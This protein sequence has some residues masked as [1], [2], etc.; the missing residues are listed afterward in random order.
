MKRA[1]ALL[2][3]CEFLATGRASAQGAP[4]PPPQTN[5]SPIEVTAQPEHG[6]P[7]T[8]VTIQGTVAVKG[9]NAVTITVKPPS[10]APFSHTVSPDANGAFTLQYPDTKTSGTYSVQAT[11]GASSA[12][13]AFGIG[14]TDIAQNAIQQVQELLRAADSVVREGKRQYDGNRAVAGAKR[15][16]TDRQIAQLQD[17]I[18]EAKRLWT[19]SSPGN[20]SV[21]PTLADILLEITAQVQRRPDLAARYAPALNQLQSWTEQNKTS[22]QRFKS[23]EP[24]L[25]SMHSMNLQYGGMLTPV[26]FMGEPPTSGHYDAMG[27]WVPDVDPSGGAGACENAQ[28]LGENFEKAASA[29]SLLGAPIDI[30]LN[31]F[32]QYMGSENGTPL[33]TP[34]K[35]HSALAV[36]ELDEW[37]HEVQNEEVLMSYLNP[38]QIHGENPQPGMPNALRIGIAGIAAHL[39]KAIS[40]AILHEVCGDYTGPFYVTVNAAAKIRGHIWWKFTV[41]IAGTL[42]LLFN[43][44]DWTPHGKV[45]FIGEFEGQ[46]TNFT[47]WEDAVPVLYQKLFQRGMTVSW[48]KV[49]ATRVTN[50]T[51]C[52]ACIYPLRGVAVAS[53][54]GGPYGT[55]GPPVPDVSNPG[56][57]QQQPDTAL[58]AGILFGETPDPENGVSGQPTNIGAKMLPGFKGAPPFNLL[59]AAY[60]RIPVEGE[61]DTSNV[62][63]YSHSGIEGETS[64]SLTV[65]AAKPDWDPD[66]I[67]AHVRYLVITTGLPLGVPLQLD[68][69]LPYPPAEFILK[70]ALGNTR[71]SPTDGDTRIEM[72]NAINVPTTAPGNMNGSEIKFQNKND[73]PETP[74]KD[75]PWQSGKADY[76]ITLTLT[77]QGSE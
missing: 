6:A 49:S 65:L 54:D 70:R 37:Q 55:F 16:A 38:G 48:H 43:N 42:T 57:A 52:N 67:N 15:A 73:M 10:G 30:A 41:R 13:A 9:S 20:S 60:F 1:I 39:G 34:T 47:V 77:K 22:L 3:L 44:S 53:E 50:L 59:S 12:A 29:I 24:L 40:D 76:S 4:A 28:Q 23:R 32:A 11:M 36:Q 45:P 66:L 26:A 64:V 58:R 75:T 21:P 56:L 27:R 5:A 51:A 17:N 35:V 31:L 19:A 8:P 71:G 33:G 62:K 68:F 61:I 18:A 72:K 2:F 25:K 69:G 14:S 63:S 74:L 46:A 7:G